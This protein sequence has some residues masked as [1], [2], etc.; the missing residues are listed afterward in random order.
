[1]TS[2]IIACIAF[3]CVFGG[4]SLGMFLRRALP[5]HHL[6]SDSKDVIKLGIGLVG[7]MSA[8]VIGL[9]ISSA[10]STFDTQNSELTQSAANVVV[11]DHLLAHY[12]PETRAA[13]DLLRRVTTDWLDQ[14]WPAAGSRPVALP[15]TKGAQPPIEAI[16]EIIR[17]LAPQSDAQRQLQSQSLQVTATLSQTRWLFLGQFGGRGI[18]MP[19]LVIL[20]A[21]LVVIFISFGLFAP[22][23][24]T[25][26]AVLLLC[27]LS[28]SGAIF[29]ILEMEH[30]FEGLM[31]VSDAPLRAAL[32]Q[33][34]Q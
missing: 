12:G 23:N 31:K 15:A 7:T 24:Q 25:V 14:L 27:A 18:P 10:K 9:L 33:L 34:D 4:A 20:I 29:L 30:P 3:A 26:I 17:G 28:A 32:A 2:T 22:P 19:F 5:E 6:S 8:L 11:L 1:M 13:R 16:Q 21:W